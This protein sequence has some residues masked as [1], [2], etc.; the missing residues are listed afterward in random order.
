TAVGKKQRLIGLSATIGE[1]RTAQAFLSPDDPDQVQLINDP[2]SKRQIKLGIKAYLRRPKSSNEKSV[3]PRI[4]PTDVQRLAEVADFNTSTL[5]HKDNAPELKPVES[6]EK[7]DS[8]DEDLEEIAVD[9]VRNFTR[10]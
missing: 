4:A 3:E 2:N 5:F 1:P 10:S 8:C 7:E 6:K 9:V